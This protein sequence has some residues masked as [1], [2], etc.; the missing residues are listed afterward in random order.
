MEDFIDRK[1]FAQFLRK[2]YLWKLEAES[3]VSS[4]ALS[5]DIEPDRVRL[6]VYEALDQLRAHS[7]QVWQERGL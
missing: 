5:N 2:E 1:W 6:R 4:I 3:W 7:R